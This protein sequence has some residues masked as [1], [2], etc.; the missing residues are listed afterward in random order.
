MAT[1]ASSAWPTT[2][3]PPMCCCCA[4]PT[5]SGGRSRSRRRATPVH[6]RRRST[7]RLEHE[8]VFK[9]AWESARLHDLPHEVLTGAELRRR[10][11][12]YHLPADTL[13]LVQ[14]EGGFLRPER[15]IVSYVKAAQALGAEIQGCEKVLE[16][17]PLA[18]GVRVRT[19][20]GVYEADKLVVSAGAWN[21]DL[22]GL[23]GWSDRARAPGAGLAPAHPSGVLHPGSLPRL[24]SPGGGGPLLRLPR[25]RRS[26]L[27]V[28]QVP[29]SRGNR[30]GR[31]LSIALP[32]PTTNACCASLPN[33]IS[34]MA[35]A[36]R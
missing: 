5:N 22:R 31:Q 36:R 13:A 15:C 1:R 24:Q 29:S 6:Y 8:W 9:G 11:P 12:G 26:R 35:A 27:Q 14:P 18:G 25:L 3:I 7:P 16:W 30:A 32:I 17:E 19:D 2:S 4:A 21:G 28:R 23:P 20:R 33:G 34:P 10:F